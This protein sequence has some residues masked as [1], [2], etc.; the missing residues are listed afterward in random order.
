MS[1][2]IIITLSW[3]EEITIHLLTHRQTAVG[4]SNLRTE[5]LTENL[6]VGDWTARCF[7]IS[8]F[9][10]CSFWGWL[11]Q[12]QC[13]RPHQPGG[14]PLLKRSPHRLRSLE[15][16]TPPLWPLENHV[17]STHQAVPRVFDVHHHRENRGP[18]APCWKAKE[19]AV[20]PAASAQLKIP[21][22]QVRLTLILPTGR[23][24][25]IRQS[26]SDFRWN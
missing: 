23:C 2:N 18:S 3:H 7:S 17:G 8:T 6:M 14:I 1:V 15:T 26:Q 24:E 11:C 5:V 19:S 25:W 20:M 21:T 10:H 16:Q 13:P 22:Q 12:A 4:E 9:W